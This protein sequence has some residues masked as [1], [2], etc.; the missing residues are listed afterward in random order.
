MGLLLKDGDEALVLE[1]GDSTDI[2][3]ALQRLAAD[4]E[5]RARIGRGGRE[6][7]LRNLDWAKNIAVIPGFYDQCL[8][9]T[10]LTAN[11]AIACDSIVPETKKSVYEQSTREAAGY[12]TLLES[13]GWSLEEL[14]HAARMREID[15][16]K[17]LQR[18]VTQ[19]SQ[20]SA[21]A[22]R[23]E[24][25]VNGLEAEIEHL[26]I[27]RFEAERKYHSIT[28]SLSWRLTWPLRAIRDASMAIFHKTQFGARLLLRRRR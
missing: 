27:T 12:R 5:L 18:Q 9:G 22:G 26:K 6:F 10:R 11:M 7:A 14:G 4:P 25:R 20:L 8:A 23:L 19:V 1:R 2:A 13:R 21:Y 3:D 28:T 17:E 15:L 24:G 16:R